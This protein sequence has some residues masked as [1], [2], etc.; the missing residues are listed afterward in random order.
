MIKSDLA[1]IL[2]AAY[3]LTS[4]AK[5]EYCYPTDVCLPGPWIIQMY[6]CDENGNKFEVRFNDPDCANETD[7]FAAPSYISPDIKCT[8]CTDYILME[9]YEQ[10]PDITAEQ[11]DMQVINPYC[12]NDYNLSSSE[13]N[14]C[15]QTTIT[16]TIYDGFGCDEDSI[17]W[18]VTWTQGCN[19]WKWYAGEPVGQLDMTNYFDII[20]C[21]ENLT[22]TTEAPTEAPTEGP[23]TT[24]GA[25]TEGPTTT[26]EAPTEGPTTTEEPAI[27]KSTIEVGGVDNFGHKASINAMYC[28]FVVCFVFLG[29]C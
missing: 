13:K 18:N 5:G 25:P 12:V 19:H 20:Y 17:T 14:S 6:E 10:C 26:T 7:Y 1:C 9:Q 27:V 29:L 16:W 21:P 28:V 11:G 22:T 15:T 24:T 8:D 2:I 3:F 4:T 23:T